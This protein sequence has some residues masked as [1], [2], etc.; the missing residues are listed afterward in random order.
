MSFVDPRSRLS[1]SERPLTEADLVADP[2][3]QFREWYSLA[4]QAGVVQPEAMVLASVDAAGQPSAR[5]VL[6]RCLDA[7]GFVFFTNYES[8]KGRELSANPRAA[9][10]FHWEPVERQVR[11]EGFVE[12]VS[13]EESDAYFK[14]RPRGS[15]IGAWAS[16]QSSVLA[17][18]GVLEQR[19]RELEVQYKDS[20]DIPRPENW[21]GLR[22]V[23]QRI[24]F[25]QGQPSRLHDRFLYSKDPAGVWRRERLSP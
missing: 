17:D 6:L 5:V 19:V 16:P 9:L 18:R 10:V 21:G 14:S 24:E 2:I 12:R 23:P 25:W 13:A 8:R 11:I 7:R 22:V 1:Q 15:R 3:E 20:E 4:A